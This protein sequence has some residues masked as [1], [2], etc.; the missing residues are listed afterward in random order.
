MRNVEI[1]RRFRKKPNMILK[2]VNFRK[3]FKI[4][5]YDH[6]L[7]NRVGMWR[8]FWKIVPKKKEKKTKRKKIVFVGPLLQNFY[9]K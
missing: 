5:Y 6:F 9:R 2:S 7:C 8:W 3:K 1:W 4:R